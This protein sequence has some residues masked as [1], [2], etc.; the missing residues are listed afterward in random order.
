MHQLTAASPRSTAKLFLLMEE[1]SYR[2]LYR[3]DRAWLGNFKISSPTSF[4]SREDDFA[5]NGLRGLADFVTALFKCIEAQMRGFAHGHGK[6]HSIPDG[7]LGLL[8]CLKDVV[9]QINTIIDI[10]G[11]EQPA[12]EVVDSIVA[13]HTKSYNSRLIQGWQ[14]TLFGLFGVRARCSVFRTCEPLFGYLVPGI[15]YLS[16]GTWYL[17]PVTRSQV[18]EHLFR[19]PESLFGVFEHL[20]V[21]GEQCS[22]PNLV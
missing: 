1:L 3:V 8:Q 12:E 10:S 15:W 16:P 9:E 7:V 11:G 14:W 2:H 13:S 4:D 20:L 6:V 5:S 22:L 18:P 17:V 19:C 21:F